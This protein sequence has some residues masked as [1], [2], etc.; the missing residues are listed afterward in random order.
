M[1]PDS[2]FYQTE[3]FQRAYVKGETPRIASLVIVFLL[4]YSF[5]I[6]LMDV[7]S[8]IILALCSS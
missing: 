5:V 7:L 3:L 6:V 8:K 4:F 1:L 2:D